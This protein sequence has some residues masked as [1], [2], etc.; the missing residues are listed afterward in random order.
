I[1]PDDPQLEKELERLALE[2]EAWEELSELYA[3]QVARESDPKRQAERHR[4]LGRLALHRLHRPEEARKH[5]EEVL[6]VAG[7]DEEAMSTLEQIFN[8]TQE[9]PALLNVYRRR[10]GGAKETQRKL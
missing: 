3:A 7:D 1:R 10:E 4:Q 2:A 6:R 5:F 8:A 9:W